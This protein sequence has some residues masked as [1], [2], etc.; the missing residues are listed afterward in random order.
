M[1]RDLALAERAAQLP[2][3][4]HPPALVERQEVIVHEVEHPHAA[5]VVEGRDR[6]GNVGDVAPLIA[7]AEP[8]GDV[9]RAGDAAIPA[10]R[11]TASAEH[12]V[13]GGKS[14]VHRL[15]AAVATKGARQQVEHRRS[16]VTRLPAGV[17]K[18]QPGHARKI[19]VEPAAEQ[20][21]PGGLAA[22]AH[23]RIQATDVAQQILGVQRGEVPASD[24]HPA[25]PAAPQ[26]LDQRRRRQRRLRGLY[27]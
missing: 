18:C 15:V 11:F 25:V 26:D 8:L 4:R 23:H 13:G 10:V 12:Q 19:L 21:D 2:D 17:A 20:R 1:R 6:P 9:G 16:A 14:Q 27:R 7:R 3:P 24:D 5:L 22:E